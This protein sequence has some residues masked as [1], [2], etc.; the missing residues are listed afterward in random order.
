MFDFDELDN[1]EESPV[2]A[3]MDINLV[4]EARPKPFLTWMQEELYKAIK[5]RRT[6]N[7][8]AHKALHL[9]EELIT[10]QTLQSN[11]IACLQVERDGHHESEIIHASLVVQLKDTLI[12]ERQ[13]LAKTRALLDEPC[14]TCSQLAKTQA[15]LEA[16]LCNAKVRISGLA[17]DNRRLTQQLASQTEDARLAQ[18]SK[19][20]TQRKLKRRDKQVAKSQQMIREMLEEMRARE[21]RDGCQSEENKRRRWYDWMYDC[22]DTEDEIEN[23]EHK[24]HQPDGDDV[25]LEYYEKFP[26]EVAQKPMSSSA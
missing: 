2:V 21:K 17:A 7:C 3:D 5:Q 11:N 16:D 6:F 14:S 4:V 19:S 12:E 10:L 23:F 20:S 22:S 18:Q 8:D 13:E 1:A 15:L 25:V 24:F 26:P 9:V